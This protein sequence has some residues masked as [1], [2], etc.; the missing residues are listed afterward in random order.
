MTR[1]RRVSY[2]RTATGTLAEFA[3]VLAVL[4]L[5]LFF[6]ISMLSLACGY[7]AIIYGTQLAA[8]EA[9][10]SPNLK[11]ARDHVARI[12]NQVTE[13]AFG[14]FGGVKDRIAGASGADGLNLDVLRLVDGQN[15]AQI[16]N[17]GT[18]PINTANSYQYRVRANYFI[19]PIFWPISFPAQMESTGV[20]EHPEG[21]AIVN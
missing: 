16:F 4:I 7:G 8:R 14:K 2:Y 6:V 3:P 1:H 15:S 21:L 20:V 10:S 13:G 11:T 19:R 5:V 18:D 17:P 12:R 9:A